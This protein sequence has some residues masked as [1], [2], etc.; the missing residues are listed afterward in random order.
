MKIFPSTLVIH[1]SQGDLN[2]L[3][4]SL[5][6]QQIQNNPDILE[7]TEYNINSIRSTT[8]FLANKPFSHSSK[9]ILINDAEKLNAESQNAL[10]KNLEEP[11]AGNYFILTTNR[12]LALLPTI[13]SRCHQIRFQPDATDKGPP[14]VVPQAIENKLLMSQELATDKIN[15]TLFL[16]AQLSISQAKLV[17][18][19]TIANHQMIKKIIKSINL[20]KANV[21]PKTALDF[22]MLS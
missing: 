15:T 13:I 18:S 1:G 8:K 12:P 19:P 2:D 9:V 21:D 11:G 22:L 3:L 7:V 4:S 6:H 10:L 20:I 14:L 5:G 17:S 16:E